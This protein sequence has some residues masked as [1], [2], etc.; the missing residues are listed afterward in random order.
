PRGWRPPPEHRAGLRRVA[1]CAG[2]WGTEMAIQTEAPASAVGPTRPRPGG[3]TR[4]GGDPPPLLWRAAAGER[5][6][7]ARSAAGEILPE[8]RPEKG[9]LQ[10]AGEI[11]QI[12]QV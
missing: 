8:V 9:L 6:S 10:L 5:A 12:R 4:P 3:R 7:A 2:P 11:G 1:A